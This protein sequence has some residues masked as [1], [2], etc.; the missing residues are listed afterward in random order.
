MQAIH[1][2]NRNISGVNKGGREWVNSVKL[3]H[4]FYEQL[5]P[6]TER[7]TLGKEKSLY[8]QKLWRLHAL[9]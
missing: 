7:P 1:V 4:Q 9:R 8:Y 6:I 2:T 5:Q 3:K